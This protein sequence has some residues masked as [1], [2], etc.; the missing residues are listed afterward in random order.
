M[1]NK[2]KFLFLFLICNLVFSQN[3]TVVSTT[4]SISSVLKEI[5][6]EKLNVITLIPPGNCPGHFDIKVKDIQILEK[7]PFLF[8][9]GYENYLE[10]I[11]RCIKNPDFKIYILKEKENWQIP[12]VHLEILKETFKILSTLF[13]K[14]K[15]YFYKNFLRVKG[16][17]EN[18]EKEI[19]RNMEENELIGKK[20]ICN[21]YLTDLLQ[22]LGFKVVD[23]YGRK[24]SLTPRKISSLIEKCREENVEIVIDNFQTGS[25]TGKVIS[26]QLK[27]HH[28]VFSN[29]PYVFKNTEDLTKTLKENIK[30]ILK[31]YGKEYRTY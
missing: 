13:P 30:R 11:K 20:I 7:T 5:G 24:E 28:V 18:F 14:E 3:Y 1:V 23:T 10:K 17:I 15:N 16:K 6:K 27:I 26:E 29:F 19:K 31:E 21:K 25:D 8:A 9:H 4:S 2:I 12:S 22:Y